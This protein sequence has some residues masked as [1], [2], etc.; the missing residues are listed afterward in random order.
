[1]LYEC[2]LKKKS[3]FYS[4]AYIKIVFL[5]LFMNKVHLLTDNEYIFKT[6]S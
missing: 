6:D 4:H 2:E 5:Y 3:Y 1:M